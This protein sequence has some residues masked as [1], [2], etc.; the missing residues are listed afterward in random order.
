MIDLQICSTTFW[1]FL[2]S[3]VFWSAVGAIATV[4][5]VVAIFFAISQI[6]FEAW[7]K[8]QEIWT[9]PE[10]TALRENLFK[11]LDSG[12]LDWSTDEEIEAKKAC[13]KLDELADLIPYLPK[14]NALKAWGVPYAKAWTILEPI[15]MK[16]RETNVW[17]EKWQAFEK[18]GK[19]ALKKYHV[20]IKK[21]KIKGST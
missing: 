17:L 6:R 1:S 2:K 20:T 7:L 10:F 21:V 16:E 12:K 9:S 8:A 4:I 19:S 11:R 13:R 15:V 3:D 14:K 5:G 18:L